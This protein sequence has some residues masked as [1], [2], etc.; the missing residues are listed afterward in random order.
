MKSAELDTGEPKGVNII[1]AQGVDTDVTITLR[2]T[3]IP[4]V[5]ALGY[6]TEISG[7]DFR[8]DPSAIIILPRAKPAR[9]R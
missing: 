3:D 5:D 8:V 4:L 7:T 9:S 6:I 1:I 2:L